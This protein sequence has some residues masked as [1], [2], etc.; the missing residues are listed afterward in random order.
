[1]PKLLGKRPLAILCLMSFFTVNAAQAAQEGVV[2]HRVA[3]STIPVAA[4]VEVPGSFST[5]YL[6]GKLPPVQDPR[7]SI[8]SPLAYGGD[9]KG[10]TIAVFKAIE[11]SL[12]DI[13]LG[14]GDV[15]KLQV[16]LVGDPAKNNKMDMEGFMEGYAQFFG[17]KNQPN[18]PAR[19][20]LKIAGLPNDAWRV[21]IEAVALRQ[22]T[23]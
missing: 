7:Q 11:K 1:M 2:R 8:T 17:T 14:L 13:G 15:V 20:V 16:F 19:S 23:L 6:S 21:E 18:V 10:Q 3:N 9:T 5:I 4:A 12:N 22:K